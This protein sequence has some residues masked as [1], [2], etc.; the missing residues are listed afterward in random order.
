[1]RGDRREGDDRVLRQAPQEVDTGGGTD[2]GTALAARLLAPR[3]RGPA[4]TGVGGRSATRERPPATARH[5]RP[6]GGT[7]PGAVRRGE[8]ERRPGG[9]PEGTAL[10]VPPLA[11]RTAGSQGSAP[12]EDHGYDRR[13]R[14]R[15]RE[16][17][18]RELPGVLRLRPALQ[19]EEGAR[20]APWRHQPVRSLGGRQ[21][22][23]G[24][25]GSAR[26]PGEG[27]LRRA[28]LRPRGAG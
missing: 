20:P 11:R 24:V 9:T 18:T 7:A 13:R 2:R 8:V 12:G 22:R 14:L 19:A 23:R 26:Q 27:R 6:T 4:R 1:G 15:D 10:I 17:G 5:R 16:A 3:A 21:G 25:P 28:H